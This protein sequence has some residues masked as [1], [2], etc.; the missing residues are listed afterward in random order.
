[1][2]KGILGASLKTGTNQGLAS[3]PAA[4]CPFSLCPWHSTRLGLLHRHPHW[5]WVPRW[6]PCTRLILVPASGW[7]CRGVE[8][9]SPQ[10]K[11]TV[12]TVS[13]LG[14]R[15]SSVL[16]VV[17]ML[18]RHFWRASPG[19]CFSLPLGDHVAAGKEGAVEL[20][21]PWRGRLPMSDPPHGMFRKRSSPQGW[22]S[23]SFRGNSPDVGQ[24]LSVWD[25]SLTGSWRQHTRPATLWCPGL[26]W[27]QRPQSPGR[28]GRKS[29]RP[30]LP[31]RL[32]CLQL[33]FSPAGVTHRQGF[34]HACFIAQ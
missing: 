30:G 19:L 15:V 13:S 33:G 7:G 21:G 10:V 22:S 17:M 23:W 8:A 18:S 11:A 6:V 20:E 5:S 26:R 32:I 12:P 2:N 28:S 3:T 34:M 29:L 16:R 1:M 14:P 25:I 31:N 27:G 24:A 4:F 9:L